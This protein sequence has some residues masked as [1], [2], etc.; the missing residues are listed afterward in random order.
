MG[1]QI[2]PIVWVSHVCKS[3]ADI[4]AQTPAR[5]AGLGD[6]ARR[7]ISLNVLLEK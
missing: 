1:R 4:G 5:Y 2:T 7:L 3:V 6:E